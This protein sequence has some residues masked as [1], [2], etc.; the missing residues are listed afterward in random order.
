[1]KL[2]LVILISIAGI[3]TAMPMMVEETAPIGRRAI[4]KGNGKERETGVPSSVPSQPKPNSESDSD[5]DSFQQQ[6]QLGPAPGPQIPK[7]GQSSKTRMEN[8]PKKDS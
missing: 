2:F 6:Q 8:T 3:A 7:P 5:S 1:M 4:M